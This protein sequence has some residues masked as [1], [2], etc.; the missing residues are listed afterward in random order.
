MLNRRYAN[1]LN[2]NAEF[3]DYL[4]VM[5]LRHG[6]KGTWGKT[7]ITIEEMVNVKWTLLQMHM[8]GNIKFPTTSTESLLYRVK[9]MCPTILSYTLMDR[10][11]T[12]DTYSRYGA[13]TNHQL[14]VVDV[15]DAAEE[16]D[17]QWSDTLVLSSGHC[18]SHLQLLLVRTDSNI[19][20]ICN[21][22]YRP[23]SG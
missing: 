15:W 21:K 12:S 5:A 2:D 20:R 10:H 8:A 19:F 13:N 6:L 9:R 16:S 22:T 17:R 4:Q 1:M 23:P 7:Q 3:G 18:A 14:L 11:M